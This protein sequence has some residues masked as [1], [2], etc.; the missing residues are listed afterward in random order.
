MRSTNSSLACPFF[1]LLSYNRLFKKPLLSKSFTAGLS[2]QEF[3]DINNKKIA[4]RY[5][6]HKIQRLSS[7][8]RKNTKREREIGAQ[9]VIDLSS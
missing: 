4:K 5:D 8:K 6:K 7:T 9:Q 2:V 3:D 1:A